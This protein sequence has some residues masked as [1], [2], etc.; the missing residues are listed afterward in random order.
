MSQL[1]Y[2]YVHDL[3]LKDLF[4]ILLLLKL[5]IS[6]KYSDYA[7]NYFIELLKTVHII[8]QRFLSSS[9]QSE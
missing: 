6:K 2:T 3:H 4:P 9:Q 5:F 7:Y 8:V 1:F